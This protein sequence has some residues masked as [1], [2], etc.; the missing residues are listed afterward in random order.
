MQGISRRRVTRPFPLFEQPRLLIQPFCV[1]PVL[2]SDP[3]AL[4]STRMNREREREH[5]VQVDRHIAECKTHIA[6]QRE[7]EL[8]RDGRDTE[9]AVSM[10]HALRGNLRSFERHRALVIERLRDA[11]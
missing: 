11:G 2:Y 1:K 6:R 9:L 7:K 4:Y 10:L 5:L 8:L 3:L